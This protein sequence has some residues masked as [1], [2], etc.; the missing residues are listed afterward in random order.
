M[1]L[2]ESPRCWVNLI[3]ALEEDLVQIGASKSQIE[4]TDQTQNEGK[5]HQQ[6]EGIL[7]WHVQGGRPKI[8]EWVLTTTN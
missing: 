8:K 6:G 1:T 7:A 3:L 5:G 2:M 4:N